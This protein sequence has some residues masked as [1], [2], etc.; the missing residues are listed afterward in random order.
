MKISILKDQLDK[1]LDHVEL[2]HHVHVP[3]L[4]PLTLRP[5]LILVHA[6]GLLPAVVEMNKRTLKKGSIRWTSSGRLSLT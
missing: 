6:A 2:L 5:E 4:D 1:A 3:D